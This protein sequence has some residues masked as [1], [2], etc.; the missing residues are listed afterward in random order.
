M[1]HSKVVEFGR[2]TAA[3]QPE[4][5]EVGWIVRAD[6]QGVWVDHPSNTQG[7]QLALCT[8]AIERAELEAAIA[9]RRGVVLLFARGEVVQPILIGLAQ[10]NPVVEAELVGAEPSSA[11]VDGRRVELEGRDE[12]VL[13]CGKA[14]ITLRRNGRIVI[15][16]VQVESRAS[17]RNRIKGGAVLIN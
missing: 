1:A 5:A 15:R 8:I 2:A 10:A 9:E 13:R 12:V 7:P 14:S 4:G 6:A 3:S 17:G 11:R 16:G